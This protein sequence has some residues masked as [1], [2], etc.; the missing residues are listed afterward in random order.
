M[1]IDTQEILSGPGEWET[2][3]ETWRGQDR[4]LLN[5]ASDEPDESEKMLSP[6][7]QKEARER[8][9]KRFLL[10][11]IG[12][13]VGEQKKDEYYPG[14]KIIRRA[15]ELIQEPIIEGE[16]KD[17]VDLREEAVKGLD[18]AREVSQKRRLCARMYVLEEK[19]DIE[20]ALFVGIAALSV[21][22][23]P[24]EQRSRLLMSLAGLGRE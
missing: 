22:K 9:Q 6:S 8:R 12:Y 20:M 4:E 15:Q 10:Q 5:L 19:G 21:G 14:T 18:R 23:V 7:E 11:T 3:L 1:T 16:K 17:I 24:P 13:V 2:R